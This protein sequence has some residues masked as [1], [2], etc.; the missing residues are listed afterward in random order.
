MKDTNA[1]F[2]PPVIRSRR[3]PLVRDLLRMGRSGRFAASF[4]AEGLRLVETLLPLTEPRLLVLSETAAKDARWRDPVCGTA[5]LADDVFAALS[6]TE[7]S[8][9]VL[10]V[11]DRPPEPEATVCGLRA[12]GLGAPEGLPSPC[13]LV[14]EDVQDP[15]NVGTLIRLAAALACTGVLVVGDSADPWSAK[16]A[17]A[18]MGALWQLPVVR[19]RSRQR[20]D[21]RHGEIWPL[22]AELG[23][24]TVAAVPEGGEP[25]GGEMG[26]AKDEALALLLGNEANGL[27]PGTLDAARRR[28]TIP[29]P[30]GAESLNVALAGAIIV[31][32]LRC[33]RGG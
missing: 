29:M 23:W 30:G 11:L 31:W 24:T 32:E 18:S 10:L 9:G 13:L 8:Q 19:L 1:S 27:D 20:G 33:R 17:R 3:N 26:F 14:L 21:I 12:A 28:I 7:T 6:T 22:L 16:V 2:V 5:V 4:P 25:L 15:G